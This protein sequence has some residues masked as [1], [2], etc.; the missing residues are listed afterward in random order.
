M[1]YEPVYICGLSGRHDVVTGGV[2]ATVCDVVIDVS[3]K[4]PRVLQNHANRG[5]KLVAVNVANIHAVKVNSA[6]RDVIEAQEQVD[7]SGLT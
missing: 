6:T 7:Q 5:A 4:Q 3:T 1:G 2:R